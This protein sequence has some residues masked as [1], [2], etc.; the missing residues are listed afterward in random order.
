[1]KAKG[2][3]FK[4]AAIWFPLLLLFFCWPGNEWMA[5]SGGCC[6]FRASDIARG[7]IRRVFSF[8]LGIQL[9]VLKSL[10][11]SWSKVNLA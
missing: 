9:L 8:A 11:Y 5:L 3:T 2:C 10:Q 1:M 4:E 6:M 7:F